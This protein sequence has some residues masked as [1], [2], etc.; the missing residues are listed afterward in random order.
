M[1]GEVK[2]LMPL[3]RHLCFLDVGHGNSTVIIAGKDSIVVVDAGRHSALSEFFIEQG[4]TH[5]Q[6]IYLSHADADHVGGLLGILTA[7]K[8]S[9]GRVYVNSDASK[10]SKVWDDLVYELDLADN[11]GLLEFKIGL[12]SG[13]REKL[14]GGVSVEVLGP[15]QYLVAKGVGSTNRSGTKIYTNS[16]S[17]VIAISVGASKVALLPGDV[18][19]VGLDDLF[20]NLQQDLHS[21]ILV[22]PHHGGFP[23]TGTTPKEHAKKLLS[24]VRPDLVIFSIGR[25]RYSTPNPDIVGQL[26]QLLPETRIVCTQLSEH[27]ADQ[28]PAVPST[29]LSEASAAGREHGACCGGTVVVPLDDISAI[30]PQRDPH[31]KFIRN[32]APT[33]LC[34]GHPPGTSST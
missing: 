6:S 2:C 3:H 9:I 25:G 11:A 31:I 23:G 10:N 34:L 22:Y 14:P 19:G 5:V 4:I 30:Q 21:R 29:H 17:A 8:V 1:G 13:H 18:D 15:S 26:R 24:K 16:I 7:Q 33:S 28:L 32:Q 27:C 12:V 20:R